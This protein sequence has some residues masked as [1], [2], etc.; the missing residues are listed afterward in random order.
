VITAEVAGRAAARAGGDGL[1]LVTRE[2]SLML[3]FAAGRPTQATAIDDFTVEIAIPFHGHVG[4][5]STNAIDDASLDECAGRASDAARA[6]TL[7]GDGRFPGFDPDLDRGADSPPAAFDAA[8]AE[9]DP[10]VGAAAL[11]DAFAVAAEQGLEAHGIWTVAEQEQAWA[12]AGAKGATGAAGAERRT[13][14]FMK[15]I[16]IAPSGRSGYASASAVAVGDVAPAELAGR[17]AAKAVAGGEL[18]ELPPGEY[19]VVFEA[20]ATGWLCDLLADCAAAS[21]ASGASRTG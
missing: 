18:A 14:V 2:R 15:V 8:T 6:A 5:A 10:G 20:Q 13:D 12:V 19:P 7:S 1:A 17:A 4:R 16:C 3:R 21:A 9:L 11:T